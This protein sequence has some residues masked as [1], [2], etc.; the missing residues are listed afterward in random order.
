MKRNQNKKTPPKSRFKSA[1]LLDLVL[2][3]WE[4][5]LQPVS[6]WHIMDDLP[7]LEVAH[8][9]TVGWLVAENGEAVMVAQS[10]AD[11]KSTDAQAGGFMRIPKSCI[12]RVS[13]LS[14]PS[15]RPD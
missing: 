11:L 2:V 8:C 5:S 13:V 3:E 12:K 9:K 4:D 14:C 6:A 7:V 15:F 10:S 1:V